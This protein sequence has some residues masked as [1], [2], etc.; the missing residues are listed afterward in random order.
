[1][2]YVE[3]YDEVDSLNVLSCLINPPDKVVFL[4]NSNKKIKRRIARYKQLFESRGVNIEF[5]SRSVSKSNLSQAVEQLEKLVQENGQCVFDITGGDEILNVAL[6][7]VYAAHPD[8]KVQI[9]RINIRN[10]TVYDCDKD[11][12]TIERNTP[13]LSVEENIGIFGGK[14]VFGDVQGCDT[15]LWQLT[16]SFRADAQTV[17]EICRAG[18]RKWNLT[19][20]TLEALLEVGDPSDDGLQVWAPYTRVVQK[21]AEKHY[22]YR[23]EYQIIDDLVDAG[24][25]TEFIEGEQVSISFKD[26]QVRRLLTRAGTALEMK[27]Y[28][29]LLDLEKDGKKVYTDCLSGVKIDW[30][31][32]PED[33]DDSPY[34]T[35]NEIDVMVMR[36]MVP[37]FISCKNGFVDSDEL[38]K[39]NTVAQHFG[40][41]YAK[42]VLVANAI[43]DSDAG[44]YLRER[45]RTMDIQL[46]E[47]VHK[48]TDEELRLELLNLAGGE[49]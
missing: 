33:E 6:G 26:L 35:E 9:H 5:E 45:L 10:N 43:P 28:L 30:D 42:M 49:C 17:W 24:L 4:G 8:G 14:V 22:T 12:I 25:V 46:V 34:D 44:E 47:N 18:L 38:Y 32:D 16:D 41:P 13:M 19:L 21:L 2:T 1:M 29:T 36:D 3:F 20:G 11:G 31:G 48:M 15:W 37:V 39:L 27:V 23:I 40:G 7:I